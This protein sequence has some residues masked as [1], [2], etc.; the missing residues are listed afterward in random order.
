MEVA[1]GHCAETDVIHFTVRSPALMHDSVLQ[2]W[3][4]VTMQCAVL[5]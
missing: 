5:H 3:P 2:R 1:I 4:S